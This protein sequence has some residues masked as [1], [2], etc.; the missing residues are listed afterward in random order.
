MS[1]ARPQ[2]SLGTLDII[3]LTVGTVVGAGI[4][5]APASVADQLVDP[6]W[7]LGA[8]L[9]GGLVSL[10]GAL[11][12]AELATAFPHVGG[13]YHFL[14][15][16]FGRRVS[17]LYG[18]ARSIVIL[19]GSIAM[20]G[21]TLGDYLT[22]IPALPALPSAAWASIATIILSV[23][24]MA[25]VRR[26]A[27]AQTAFLVLTLTG[28]AAVVAAGFLVGHSGALA[29]ASASTPSTTP[30]P[31]TGGIGLAMVFVLLTYGGWNEAAY[32]SAE[33]RDQRRGVLSGLLWGLAVVTLLYLLANWAYLA[34]LGSAGLARADAPA[35]ALVRAAYGPAS[36]LLLSGFV[37]FSCMKS[38]NATMFFGARSY[39]AL[40]QDVEALRFMGR[41][42]ASGAPRAA[43]VVQ[44]LL[45]LSLISLAAV[46]RH[47][48]ESAVEFTAPVFWLFIFLVSIALFVIR[49][50]HPDRPAPFRGPFYPVLPA[51]FS[52]AALWL[53][54]SS[55]AYAG[56]ASLVGIAYLLAGLVPMW[57]AER[58]RKT[59]GD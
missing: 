53:L 18:W 49:R 10:V 13:E 4:F 54:W 48:F 39:F 7:I 55:V 45:T 16:A 41:W 19:P 30:H 46:G 44:A 42:H 5:R 17:F 22:Q 31:S 43:I 59:S 33:A 21:I 2:P 1:D 57:L 38:M 34:V 37:A 52:M 9:A 29:V 28:L 35:A 3:A 14:H 27:L 40:G 6:W 51:V 58:R 12:Y 15:Q 25:G 11:T 47:Q 26:V 23:L 20:L 8:W 36:T 24:N 56:R 32:V 50:R